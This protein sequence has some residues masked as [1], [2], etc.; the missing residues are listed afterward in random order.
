MVNH[1]SGASRTY[2][3]ESEGRIVAYYC[4]AAGSLEHAN[5]PGSMRRNMPDP[6]PIVVMG[7]LAI[8]KNFQ[9]KGIGA[10]LL[11]N[12]LDRTSSVSTQIGIRAML[13]HAKDD[14]AVAFYKHFGFVS[15]PIDPLTLVLRA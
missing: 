6:L 7:R 10:E 8:D 12:A 3:S 13:V 1:I 9:G 15:S 4:L 14:R 2:V 11:L 5:A